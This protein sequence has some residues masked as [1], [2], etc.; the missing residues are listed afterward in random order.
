MTNP[1]TGE[2]ALVVDGVRHEMRL[3]LGALAELEDALGDAGLIPLIE[4]FEAGAFSAADLI[5]L[6]LAGLRGGGAEI[7]Q[8]ELSKAD[9]EGGAG[10]AAQAAARVLARAFSGG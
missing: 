6:L 5:A 1:W 9:I 4:R 3:R 10:A 8:A 7:T 2:V